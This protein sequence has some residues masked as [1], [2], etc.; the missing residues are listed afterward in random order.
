VNAQA[1]LEFL[2]GGGLLGAAWKVSAAVRDFRAGVEAL[3]DM[4]TEHIHHHPG[5]S[6]QENTHAR[7][8]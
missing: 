3:R 5:P 6:P 4:V 7:A 2:T 1:W 8:R